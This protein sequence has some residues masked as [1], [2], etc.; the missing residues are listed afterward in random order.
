MNN[1]YLEREQIINHLKENLFKD[2]SVLACFL[3]WSDAN[4]EVDEWSDI[5][6][7]ICVQDSYLAHIFEKVKSILLSLSQIDFESKQQK[8][9]NQTLKFFHLKNTHKSLIIDIGVILKNNIT[10]FEKNHPFFKP[11][12]LFDKENVIK[13]T[14]ENA[15]ILS[16]NIS[17]FK[18]EQID[19]FSQRYRI[20]T[21][22]KRQNYI[23]ATNYYIKILYLPLIW[24]L[25]I[26]YTPKLYNWWRIHISRHFSK[27]VVN[28]LEDLMK[29]QN[30]EDLENNF[31]IASKWF[32]EEIGKL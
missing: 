18:Q 23:E 14:A 27:E 13:F 1:F 6:F 31:V 5:D 9:W 19:F 29:F 21:Y 11:K 16:K 12:V 2:N 10:P 28:K 3:W 15:D 17:D 4:N 20:I 26:K 24:I 30:L 22:I 25:R 7:F 8:E 32:E